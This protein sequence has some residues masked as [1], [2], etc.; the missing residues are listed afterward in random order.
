LPFRGSRPVV[1]VLCAPRLSHCTGA[2]TSPSVATDRR[3][4]WRINCSLAP[5]TF[6]HSLPRYCAEWLTSGRRAHPSSE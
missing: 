2:A 5:S 3:S 6:A 1:Q 4:A